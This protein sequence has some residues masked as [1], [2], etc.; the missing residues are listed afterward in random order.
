MKSGRNC[1]ECKKPSRQGDPVKF[2]KKDRSYRHG[3]CRPSRGQHLRDQSNRQWFRDAKSRRSD[4]D[5]TAKLMSEDPD[6]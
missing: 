2:S 1:W 3:A 6:R 5:R 4:L